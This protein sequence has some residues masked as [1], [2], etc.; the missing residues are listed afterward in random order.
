[1]K[2]LFICYNII[3][4]TYNDQIDDLK[5]YIS[6][7]ISQVNANMVSKTDL[8]DLQAHIDFRLDEIQASIAESLS[9]ANDTVD[10]QISAHDVRLTK[11]EQSTAH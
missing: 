1:M 11:L 8:A 6:T 10:E 7:T 5:Q 3:I 9:V 2:N 4:I